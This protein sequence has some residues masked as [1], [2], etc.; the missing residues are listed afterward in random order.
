L[1]IAVLTSSRAD[2]SILYPL[3]KKLYSEN[4]YDLD[5]IAF[6]THLSDYYGKTINKIIE[7]GFKVKYKITT[8]PISDTP[9]NIS[10]S[11]GDTINKFSSIWEN[12]SYD[13]LVALGD[14][15][16]MFAA[17]VSTIPFNIKIAHIHGGETTRGAFDD[18]FRNAIT[19]MSLIH[20]TA[21]E[22]YQNKVIDMK[23]NSENVF[24][25]GALSIDN[26]K[27]I[28]LYTIEEFKTVYNIDLDYPS[29]LITFQPE[30]V[31]YKMNAEYTDILI[32]VFSAIRGYQLII[33]MP[34]ADTMG[35]T[36]R[37]KFENFIQNTPY[38]IKIES[39]GTKGYL[40]CM[41]Y[42]KMML[43]NSSSGFI[44][45][46]YFSK[47]VINVGKRQEGRIITPN[48]RNTNINKDQILKLVKD[49]ENYI[50][51]EYSGIYGNGDAALKII[52]YIKLFLSER[53]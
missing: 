29:I 20:F 31:N 40:S 18:F 6:G 46:S 41:K 7:D 42:C 8:S 17:C 22:K 48:I 12:E 39:F 28:N 49:F 35:N 21:S 3:L 15:Y 25:V 30:T 16:E 38:A 43:G 1:K 23:F 9:S 53:I 19:Q 24:N 34:N 10:K 5:I 4:E 11:I 47:Y 44:E 32:D 33:T 37:G 14:R 26:L 51:D 2:Y 52:K 45:A 27:Q 36:I 50:P 13:L